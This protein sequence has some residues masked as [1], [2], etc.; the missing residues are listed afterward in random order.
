MRFGVPT[1]DG[2]TGDSVADM[3]VLLDQARRDR[4]ML[5]ATELAREEAAL[6]RNVERTGVFG[7]WQLQGGTKKTSGFMTG[8]IGLA[9]PLPLFNRNSG[10]RLRTD[11]AVREADAAARV[12]RLQVAGEVEAAASQLRRLLRMRDRLLGTPALGNTIAESARV[13]YAE[14]EMSLLELLDAERAAADAR[15][16]AQQYAA[17]LHLARLTLARAIGAPLVPGS[18]R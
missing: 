12:L 10:A 15:R 18:A 9:V 11:N 5:R 1:M 8:Q 2:A 7:D 17:D 4:A 16:A 14:G 3:Q 13:A 6:R